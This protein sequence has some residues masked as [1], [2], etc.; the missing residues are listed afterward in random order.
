MV[1]SHR[2]QEI[3]DL[4][5]FGNQPIMH[6]LSKPVLFRAH[7]GA[8]Y[9]AMFLTVF[10]LQSFDDFL[11]DRPETYI[12]TDIETGE[13]YDMV[14]TKYSDID[15]SD[16]VYERRYDLRAID[17]PENPAAYFNS[18]YMMLDDV[19]KE[20]IASGTLNLRRYRAYMKR[21]LRYCPVPYRRFFRELSL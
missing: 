5:L 19:R 20:S 10:S 8:I 11:F 4:Q 6:G 7:N 1:P 17:Y 3:A 14:T 18:T 12:L 15:F 16:A 21:I 13:V 2:L 9:N